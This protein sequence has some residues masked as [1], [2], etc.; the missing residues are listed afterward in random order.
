MRHNLKA[1]IRMRFRTQLA[2][3]RAV[4]LHP[5]RLNRLCCGWID[6]TDVERE[7]LADALKA[8]SAWLFSTVMFI[9][10]S[11]NSDKSTTRSCA[12][13]EVK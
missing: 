7:R 11:S 10:A 2:C 4:G 9:P 8:D 1:A 3:A 5:I 13:R 12:G 6:P